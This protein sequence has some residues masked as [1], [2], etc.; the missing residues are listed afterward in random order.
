VSYPGQFD[1]LAARPDVN[2]VAN[3]TAGNHVEYRTSNGRGTRI[4]MTGG[5]GQAAGIFTFRGGMVYEISFGVRAVITAGAAG[6]ALLTLRTNPGAADVLDNC[7][8]AMSIFV[9]ST[10]GVT[11]VTTGAEG[12]W[13]RTFAADTSCSVDIVTLT[14]A[15]ITQI[16]L[17][18]WFYAQAIR[19]AG[20]P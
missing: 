10:Q 20:A 14:T 3:L 19:E 5:A 4:S 6:V 13:T 18:S 16:N 2:Q 7:G 11:T 12:R 8:I 1:Y 9:I 15:T 17:I